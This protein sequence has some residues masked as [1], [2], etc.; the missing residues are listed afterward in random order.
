MASMQPQ[1]CCAPLLLLPCAA[2]GQLQLTSVIKFVDKVSLWI[3]MFIGLLDSRVRH[4]I[5][6]RNRNPSCC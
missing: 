5:A 4:H 1:A 2:L 6:L 3:W